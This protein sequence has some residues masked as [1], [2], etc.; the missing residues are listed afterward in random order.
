MKPPAEQ[1]I[2]DYLNRLSVAA[3]TRLQSD[4]RRAFLARTRDFIERQ[5]GAPETADPAAVMRI[6]SG[7][8][9]PDAAVEREAARLAALRSER[10]AA[11]ARSGLW[12]SRARASADGDGRPGNQQGNENGA[13]PAAA[14]R[15]ALSRP[16]IGNRELTG[17][18]TI[19]SRPISARFKPGAPL[20][21]RQSRPYRVPRP[22]RGGSRPP[23]GNGPA[24]PGPAAGQK[25][26]KE[27]AA[28]GAAGAAPPR[29]LA[30]A[31]P[32][33]SRP[34]AAAGSAGPRGGAAPPGPAPAG[35][36]G[37]ATS[38]SAG[39]RGGAAPTGPRGAAVSQASP[40]GAVAE[41]P[42]SP[43]AQ[44]RVAVPPPGRPTAPLTTAR[45]RRLQLVQPTDV[46]RNI[47]AAVVDAWRQHRL[48]VIAVALLAL[49]GLIFPSPIWLL[50][51]LLWLIG[52]GIA[53][54]SKLWSG[55]DKWVA[56]PGLVALVLVG[57][58]TAVSLGGTRTGAA[59]YGD[60]A[61]A[62]ATTLFRIG[63]L[64]GAVYLA[65]RIRH[66]RRAPAVPPW[67][68]HRSH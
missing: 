45:Q 24:A 17:E 61:V 60:E 7:I 35:A 44:P 6:L 21:Q 3:R 33:A 13:E 62:D 23:E 18:I 63:A 12:K 11:A 42:P 40:G 54:S 27:T 31:D 19:T 58:A 37:S 15:P 48:E 65:W 51:F 52:A 30:P 38:G 57:T 8:G 32:A 2:R 67:V 22:R 26:A 9:E 50:G 41:A 64:L 29:A 25:P 14:T 36:A 1:L 28:S 55:A 34:A 56:I 39:P 68:R 43:A 66:G 20:K 5:S 4:D 53:L 59:A 49:A 47:A 16:K 46:T 10:A